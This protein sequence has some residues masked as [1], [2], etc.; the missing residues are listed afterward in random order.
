MGRD[1]LPA[2]PAA[3]GL[4]WTPAR[5]ALGSRITS[6]LIAALEWQGPTK[7]LAKVADRN[8]NGIFDF[9]GNSVDANTGTI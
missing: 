1:G 5:E 4:R 6:P 7:G 8:N 2:I 9:K 3:T